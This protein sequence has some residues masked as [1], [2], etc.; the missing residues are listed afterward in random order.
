[1]VITILILFFT[2]LVYPQFFECYK[3]YLERTNDSI[4]SKM[5]Q[6]IYYIH[7]KYLINIMLYI[8]FY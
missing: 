2:Y 5:F 7:N 1:M 6:N 8:E 4:L 3:E